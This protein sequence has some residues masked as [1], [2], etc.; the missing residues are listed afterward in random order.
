MSTLTMGRLISF[1]RTGLT[2]YAYLTDGIDT[3]GVNLANSTV[4]A[5]SVWQ[6]LADEASAYWTVTADVTSAGLLTLTSDTSLT[7]TFTIDTNGL[8]GFSSTSYGPATTFTA[9]S[10]PQGAVAASWGVRGYQRKHDAEGALTHA[11]TSFLH[12]PA[13]N[14]R[15]LDVSAIL[16]AD[17]AVSL[18][19]LIGTDSAQWLRAY[20]GK[21]DVWTDAGILTF[22][23]SRVSSRATGR[24]NHQTFTFEGIA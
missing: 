17:D 9:E 18:A 24:S 4:S 23:V 11:R 12:T 16:A 15:P 3:V 21:A 14:P 22:W 1:Y 6:A 10:V 2:G 13:T 20:P 7:L 19:T 5:L 8:L